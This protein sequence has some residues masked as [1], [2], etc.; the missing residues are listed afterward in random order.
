MA[1]PNFNKLTSYSTV[2][3]AFVNTSSGEL[4][5]SGASN[6]YADGYSG[7]YAKYDELSNTVKVNASGLHTHL[8]QEMPSRI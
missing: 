1:T 5:G 3:V 8:M 7:L 6:G 4:I 2:K